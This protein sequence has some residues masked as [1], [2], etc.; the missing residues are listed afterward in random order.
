MVQAGAVG[1]QHAP[2]G[3]ALQNV[4]DASPNG[5]GPAV[6]VQP[7]GPHHAPLGHDDYHG[8]GLDCCQHLIPG[9]V[10]FAGD[11]DHIFSHHAEKEAHQWTAGGFVG[12]GHES[13]KSDAPDKVVGKPAYEKRFVEAGMV[14]KGHQP[15]VSPRFGRRWMHPLDIEPVEDSADSLNAPQHGID[16]LFPH[17]IPSDE[18]L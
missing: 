4:G 18:P 13:L 17:D 5:H 11:G 12:H 8:I 9:V 6:L 2:C 15:Q 16:A 1:Q 3:D 7:V 14:E 10:V